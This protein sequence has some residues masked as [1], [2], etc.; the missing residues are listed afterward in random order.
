MYSYKIIFFHSGGGRT[1]T[2]YAGRDPADAVQAYIAKAVSEGTAIK[3]YIGGRALVVIS[4]PG[5][6]AE[7]FELD[8]PPTPT[9]VVLTSVAL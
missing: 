6:E 8:A 3:R 7:M 4:G 1:W 2:N 5:V 9:P